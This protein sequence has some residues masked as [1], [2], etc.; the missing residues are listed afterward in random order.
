MVI[1]KLAKQQAGLSTIMLILVVGFF[2]YIIYMGLKVVPV[3]MDYYSIRSAVDGLADEMK[4]RQIS[5]NQY[6][7]LLRRRLEINYI[8]VNGLKPSRD[9]CE[10]SN[11]DVFHYKNSKK[12]TEV[13]VSYEERVSLFANIDF[14]LTFDHMRI[15]KTPAK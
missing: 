11:R 1:V 4:T 14:L 7:D 2:G 12:G 3:Y 8:N 10:K 5:K 9:G 15:V 13:G 6:M